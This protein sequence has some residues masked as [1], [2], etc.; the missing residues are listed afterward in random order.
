MLLWLFGL[1]DIL[2][3]LGLL[4]L[5]SAPANLIFWLGI[6]VLIKGIASV[7]GATLQKYF[8]DWMGWVDLIVGVC[9]LLHF[10]VPLLWLLVMAKGLWSLFAGRSR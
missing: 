2:A 1:L 9:L 5:N 4:F 7:G 6:L 8:F 10:S 3:G